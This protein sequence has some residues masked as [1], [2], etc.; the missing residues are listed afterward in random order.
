[1]GVSKPSLREFVHFKNVMYNGPSETSISCEQTTTKAHNIISLTV[2]DS[3]FNHLGQMC[4][5]HKLLQVIKL[6]CQ[7]NF[8][9]SLV[10]FD[11]LSKEIFTS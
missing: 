11:S 7:A 2:S 8:K 4:P 9:N 6:C 5:G 3:L 10:V 1:M